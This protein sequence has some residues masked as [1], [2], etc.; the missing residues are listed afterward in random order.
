MNGVELLKSKGPWCRHV[1]PLS[2]EGGG[3]APGQIISSDLVVSMSSNFVHDRLR[4]RTLPLT[5]EIKVFGR[6]EKA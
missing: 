1:W 3:P 4:S 2:A 6:S 5:F